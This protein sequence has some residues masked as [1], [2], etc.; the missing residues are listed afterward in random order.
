M[1]GSGAVGNAPVVRSVGYPGVAV[2]EDFPSW[3]AQQLEMMRAELERLRI[4]YESVVPRGPAS[5]PLVGGASRNC[6]EAGELH[7]A[8]SSGSAVTLVVEQES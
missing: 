2:P 1:P 6:M 8:S 3:V 5:D 4:L 7:D